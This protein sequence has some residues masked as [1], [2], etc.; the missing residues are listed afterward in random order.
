MMDAENPC[1][2]CDSPEPGYCQEQCMIFWKREHDELLTRAQQLEAR[3]M[4]WVS[5]E[6]QLP[7]DEE[8]VDILV[9]GR[10]EINAQYISSDEAFYV[11]GDYYLVEDNKVTHWMKTPNPPK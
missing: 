7:K 11:S 8:R 5:V 1:L 2:K 9:N 4:E 10:R 3:A 6:E